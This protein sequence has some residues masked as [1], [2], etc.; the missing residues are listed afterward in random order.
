MKMGKYTKKTG[1]PKMCGYSKGGNDGESA[2]KNMMGAMNQDYSM[3]MAKGGTAQGKPVMVVN[4]RTT[5]KN[6][7][8]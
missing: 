1:Q 8:N 2:R 3:G 5:R 4:S 7:G 6:A